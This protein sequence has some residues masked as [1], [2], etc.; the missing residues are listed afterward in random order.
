VLTNNHVIAESTSVSVTI[1]GDDNNRHSAKVLG[2]DIADDIALIQIQGVS[3]LHT[4]SLGAASTLSVGDPIVAIGNAGGQGGT[5]SAVTGNVTALNQQITASDQDGSNAETL[6]GLVKVDADIQPGDSGGPLVDAN[7]KVVGMDAAAS[8]SNGGYGF[9]GR[10]GG[11]STSSTS[12]G[13]AIPIEHA[14]SIAKK[15]ASG[16]GGTNIHIGANRGILGVEVQDA[17]A[18][19]LGNGGFG[20]GQ[21][22]NGSSGGTTPGANVVAVQSGSGAESAGIAQ[23]DVIVSING[24]TVNSATDLT[25]A[26]VA[27]APKDKVDVKWIDSSGTSHQASVA[28]SS[29]PPA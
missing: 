11:G 25:H 28:L 15:I 18:T 6:S 29:G 21:S 1:G 16:D 10:F 24:K 20:G 5:P 9:G 13:Y 27:Y 26:I 7:G 19:D 2:Y 4:A 3:G 8:S 12:E 17:G 23:G 22:G 14:V